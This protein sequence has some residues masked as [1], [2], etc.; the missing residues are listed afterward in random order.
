M[1]C[2]I[3]LPRSMIA[4]SVHSFSTTSRMWEV[5]K[6]VTPV[7]TR[8]VIRSLSCREAMASIPSNGSSRNS[9]RGWWS[10][11]AE[12]ASFFFIPWL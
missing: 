3:S 10:S 7:R 6:I 5:R 8:E 4:M 12:N 9:R 1:L 11:A 2:V